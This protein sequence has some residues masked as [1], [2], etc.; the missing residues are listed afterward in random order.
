MVHSLQPIWDWQAEGRRPVV[1]GLSVDRRENIVTTLLD[2]EPQQVLVLPGPTIWPLVAAIATAVGF[3]GL[4]F[5]PVFYVI[6]FF[7]AF[8]AFVGWLWPRG[9]WEGGIKHG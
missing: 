4:L 9:S 6:G 7:T 5:H 8:F 3:I 2:A 1:D